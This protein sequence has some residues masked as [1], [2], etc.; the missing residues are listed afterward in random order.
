MLCALCP[1]AG[2]AIPAASCTDGCS[3]PCCW[4]PDCDVHPSPAILGAVLDVKDCPL[5]W[6]LS[7]G[8]AAPLSVP[9]GNTLLV[10]RGAVAPSGDK[11][12]DCSAHPV[13]SKKHTP[14]A[15]V[16]ESVVASIVEGYSAHPS[17][18]SLAAAVLTGSWELSLRQL[19]AVQS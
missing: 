19:G 4:V 17:R 18:V 8:G 2:F 3:V 10:E 16:C 6:V 15:L 7:W 12:P 14:A 11:A 13:V 5:H 1:S 9:G